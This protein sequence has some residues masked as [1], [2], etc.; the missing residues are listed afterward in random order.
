MSTVG[1]GLKVCR[2]S[3]CHLESTILKKRM[4]KQSML[5]VLHYYY[6]YY[7]YEV[8]VAELLQTPQVFG[9]CTSQIKAKG[10]RR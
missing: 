5:G 3:L 2:F 9:P 6:Y 4:V 7:L 10:K 8:L 1:P